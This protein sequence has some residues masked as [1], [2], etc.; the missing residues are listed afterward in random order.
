MDSLSAR[1]GRH[2]RR[3][4]G[5]LIIAV[6]CSACAALPPSVLDPSIPITPAQ[7]RSFIAK[8]GGTILAETI[9]AGEYY[10]FWHNAEMASCWGRQ[11]EAEL[12]I[13]YPAIQDPVTVFGNRGGAGSDGLACVHI[14]DPDLQSRAVRMVITYQDGTSIAVPTDGKAAF[15]LPV[16]GRDHINPTVT[17]YDQHDASIYVYCPDPA[18]KC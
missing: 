12:W 5:L 6:A 10:V 1:F 2:V 8:Q 11:S 7:R 17:F 4:W 3:S 9:I 18:V 15:I 16:A 14:H 13:D